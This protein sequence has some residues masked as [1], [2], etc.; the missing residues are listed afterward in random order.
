MTVS[1]THIVS[2]THYAYFG[3]DIE[4]RLPVSLPWYLPLNLEIVHS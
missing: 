2:L 1:L 4:L 3:N